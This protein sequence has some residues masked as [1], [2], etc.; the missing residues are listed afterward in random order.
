MEREISESV[1]EELENKYFLIKK[2]A[3]FYFLGGALATAI[4]L[5][6]LSWQA[7]KKAA[8][9]VI[10]SSTVK[11]IEGDLREIKLRAVT[12]ASQITEVLDTVPDSLKY[13]TY[14][15]IENVS[16]TEK[17]KLFG[18]ESETPLNYRAFVVCAVV[19]TQAPGLSAWLVVKGGKNSAASA[20]KAI[21]HE[22]TSIVARS[23]TPKLEVDEMNNIVVS[24]YDHKGL[25]P[26]RCSINQLTP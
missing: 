16:T 12:E 23:N 11:G 5:V 2:G 14:V 20:P 18:D 3:L 6:G 25:Y 21:A 9:S 1:I 8:E 26:V 10:Q 7:S 13:Q 19:G 17:K 15:N 22:I 4:A 24:L